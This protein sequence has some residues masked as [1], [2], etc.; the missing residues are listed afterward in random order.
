VLSTLASGYNK[1]GI[2][3]LRTCLFACLLFGLRNQNPG[4][5]TT[6]FALWSS[7]LSL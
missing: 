5:Q 6:A 4:S 3:C 2:G 1:G 7:L